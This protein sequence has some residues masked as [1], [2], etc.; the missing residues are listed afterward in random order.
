MIAGWGSAERLRNGNEA[1]ICADAGIAV[2]ALHVS[3]RFAR[4]GMLI[5]DHDPV[6]DVLLLEETGFESHTFRRLGVGRVFDMSLIREFETTS[7]RDIQL[8]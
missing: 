4:S 2:H 7:E 3:T 8:V 5:K 1:T 6:L